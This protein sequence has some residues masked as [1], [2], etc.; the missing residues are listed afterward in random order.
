VEEG[1]TGLKGRSEGGGE[2]LLDRGFE[3]IIG[4]N[5]ADISLGVRVVG[6]GHIPRQRRQ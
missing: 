1:V 5:D 4:D 2:E 3:E 6:F